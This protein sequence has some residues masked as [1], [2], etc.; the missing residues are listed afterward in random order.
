MACS[1]ST[2]IRAAPMPQAGWKQVENAP[3]L[4]LQHLSSYSIKSLP[5]LY[6]ILVATGELRAE[7]CGPA[8]DGSI[9]GLRP[10]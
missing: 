1:L 7:Q 4:C 9:T 6:K 5:I 10:E 2:S 8:A 3:L